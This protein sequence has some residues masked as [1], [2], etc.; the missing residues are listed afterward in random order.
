[1]VS[2]DVFEEGDYAVDVGFLGF[3]EFVLEW[4]FVVEFEE[5]VAEAV[6]VG[7]AL[8]LDDGVVGEGCYGGGLGGGGGGGLGSG[9]G[10]GGGVDA[11]E[12][13]DLFDVAFAEAFSFAVLLG[14]C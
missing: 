14:G 8:V 1:M 6:G 12:F 4:D 10:D 5:F 13:S 7:E 11:E 3:D 9:G 2:G